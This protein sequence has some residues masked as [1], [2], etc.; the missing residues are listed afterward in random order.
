MAAPLTIVADAEKAVQ[1]L[2]QKGTSAPGAACAD[3][4]EQS[5][6]P[7]FCFALLTLKTEQ[8][9]SIKRT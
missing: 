4:A 2:F 3:A 1:R 9:R 6:N 8:M 7:S 5:K